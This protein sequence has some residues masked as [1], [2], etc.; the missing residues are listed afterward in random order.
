MPPSVN[1][2]LKRWNRDRFEPLVRAKIPAPAY[3]DGRRART[4]GRAG[5]RPPAAHEFGGWWRGRFLSFLRP[6]RRGAA[7]PHLLLEV[8]A[9]VPA[10][11]PSPSTGTRTGSLGVVVPAPLVLQVTAHG[12]VALGGVR[13]PVLAP[14]GC[15]PAA[16][17]SLALRLLL[18]APLLPL[19]LRRRRRCG[20]CRRLGLCRRSSRAQQ[21]EGKSKA[22][23]TASS[24]PVSPRTCSRGSCSRPEARLA[25]CR[26][27][28]G[29]FV[30]HQY[31]PP[32]PPA[33]AKRG[34]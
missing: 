6:R 22:G 33:A 25:V 23:R 19:A 9:P 17:T 21:I 16:G 20:L 15:G 14:G 2:I 24:R 3:R 34:S 27:L 30:A 32:P 29:R 11:V 18:P 12:L 28:H 5:V 26:A 10:A 8:H 1:V 7:A 4:S 13:I 31:L